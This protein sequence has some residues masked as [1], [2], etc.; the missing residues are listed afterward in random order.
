MFVMAAQAHHDDRTA[1]WA[2]A[3][4]GVQTALVAAEPTRYFRPPYVGHRGWVGVYL[5]VEVDWPHVEEVIEDA[6]RCVAPE[7]LVDELDHP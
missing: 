3:P 4:E 2:A 1:I 7:R 5:D 6:W